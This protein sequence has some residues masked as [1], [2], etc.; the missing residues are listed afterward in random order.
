MTDD[1]SANPALVEAL[2]PLIDSFADMVER[3]IK[4]ALTPIEARV[5]E[6]ERQVAEL[7]SKLDGIEV[8]IT[9]ERT[10]DEP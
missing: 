5:V 7:T 8:P 2:M 3:H 6:L 1:A 9:E 10:Q 4:V